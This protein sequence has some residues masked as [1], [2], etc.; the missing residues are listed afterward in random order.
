MP[1][2]IRLRVIA[3]MLSKLRMTVEDAAEEL[4]RICEEVYA[5]GLSPEER[6]RKLR[7]CILDLLKRRGLPE[8]LK[9]GTDDRVEEGCPW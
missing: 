1:A 9:M 3:I 6:T 7:Q 8:D 2:L 4:Y 5:L